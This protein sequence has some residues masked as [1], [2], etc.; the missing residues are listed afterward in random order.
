MRWRCGAARRA[1]RP[2]APRF[3]PHSRLFLPPPHPLSHLP[4]SHATLFAPLEAALRAELPDSAALAPAGSLLASPALAP[5][6]FDFQRVHARAIAVRL[7]S[8]HVVAH[9][10]RL[11]Q[12]LYHKPGA[13]GGAKGGSVDAA[14]LRAAAVEVLYATRGGVTFEAAAAAGVPFEMEVV[15]V[16][17]LCAQDAIAAASLS[18]AAHEALGGVLEGDGDGDA[19]GGGGGAAAEALAAG[20]VTVPSPSALHSAPQARLSSLRALYADYTAAGELIL[21]PYFADPCGVHEAEAE[22]GAAAASAAI[23]GAPTLFCY[24]C[25]ASRPHIHASPPSLH[26]HVEFTRARSHTRAPP[27]SSFFSG[28]SLASSRC[29]S[30][31]SGAARCAR[32][33]RCSATWPRSCSAACATWSASA[34]CRCPPPRA[35]SPCST[36]TSPSAARG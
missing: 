20:G 7:A 35:P 21:S 27:P 14:R 2:P 17:P 19:G 8:T 29:R 10:L 22:S 25:V 33:S 13:E 28:L 26:P 11:A 15:R 30:C 5:S 24:E 3:L 4:Q 1:A 18:L 16:P 23:L 31:C 32:R 34:R 12:R 36:C 9:A 6:P